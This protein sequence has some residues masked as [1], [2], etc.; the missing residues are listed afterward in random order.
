MDK[1]TFPE[2]SQIKFDD[3]FIFAKNGRI[4]FKK[5]LLVI[6]IYFG[7]WGLM[8]LLAQTVIK[9]LYNQLVQSRLYYLNQA[10]TRLRALTQLLSGEPA[11]KSDIESIDEK[12]GTKPVATEVSPPKVYSPFYIT[13]SPLVDR[14]NSLSQAMAKLSAVGRNTEVNPTKFGLQELGGYLHQLQY[15]HNSTAT[16]NDMGNQGFKANQRLRSPTSPTA[17][18][19]KT[20]IRSV[21]GILLS[22]RNFPGLS[23]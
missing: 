12:G 20:E 13:S 6:Y 7:T 5:Y 23:R 3:N 4:S 18:E 15:Y 19:V 1:L 11:D 22:A 8:Y 16:L 17:A 9:P 21:K 2:T 14:L 10:L